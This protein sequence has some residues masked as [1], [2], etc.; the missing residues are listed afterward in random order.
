MLNQTE[1]NWLSEGGINT[2]HQGQ[3][4]DESENR[5]SLSLAPPYDRGRFLMTMTHV[6]LGQ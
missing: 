2:L 1:V 4:F 5:E 3:F 6:D